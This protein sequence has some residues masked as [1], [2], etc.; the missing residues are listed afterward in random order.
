MTGK[1]LFKLANSALGAIITHGVLN[2]EGT[3][4]VAAESGDVL[5]WDMK[6]REVIFY[7]KQPNIQ[8]IFFYDN[9]TCCIVVSREGPIG[10]VVT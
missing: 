2:E 1:L 9:E 7:E 4:T 3:Y 5:Y 8:Q 10:R 6:T